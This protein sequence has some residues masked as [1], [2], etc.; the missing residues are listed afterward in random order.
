[1]TIELPIIA[2]I[3]GR[4]EEGSGLSARWVRAGYKVIIGSRSAD[5]AAEFA[6]SIGAEG[7]DNHTAAS[8]CDIA[9]LTVPYSV[10]KETLFGIKDALQGKILVD[11]TV[12]LVPPRVMRVQLPQEGSAAK[13]AQAV[14]GQTVDVVS[15]FQNISSSLELTSISAITALLGNV[16]AVCISSARSSG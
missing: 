8:K 1:M 15:A 7:T 12:P 10:Q 14:L 6:S 9:V 11:V 4:G 2:V 5:K 13:A 16:R 3:G